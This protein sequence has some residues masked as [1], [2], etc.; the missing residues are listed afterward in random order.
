MRKSVNQK[1]RKKVRVSYAHHFSKKRR[2][3]PL[4]LNHLCMSCM[5]F[6]CASA[7]SLTLFITS[8]TFSCASIYLLE[9]LSIQLCSPMLRSGSLKLE[10]HFRKQVEDIFTKRSLYISISVL[11]RNKGSGP[12][13]CCPNHEDILDEGGRTVG[14]MRGRDGEL[15]GGG[16]RDTSRRHVAG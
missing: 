11:A 10:R 8:P 15:V 9:H 2:P 16:G 7:C 1:R 12:E 4:F 6:C 14:R 13:D 5:A 3:A